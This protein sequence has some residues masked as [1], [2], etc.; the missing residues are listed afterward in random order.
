[1][2]STA[3]TNGQDQPFTIDNAANDL[4]PR[5]YQIDK[6]S[7]NLRR[8][9]WQQ[10][11]NDLDQVLDEERQAWSRRSQKDLRL[12]YNLPDA[13]QPRTAS[14]HGHD[15]VA[16]NTRH[17]AQ[18]ESA[19]NQ[20]KSNFREGSMNEGSRATAS[21]W[22]GSLS[23][24]TG[25][26][27]ASDRSECS[28]DDSGATPRPSIA[29]RASTS[30]SFD[31]EEFKPPPV[32]PSTLKSTIKRL[33][34]KLKPGESKENVPTQMVDIKTHRT[35]KRG[36][37]KS[38]STWRI[39]NSTNT[40]NEGTSDAD[41][42]RVKATKTSKAGRRVKS[43]AEAD[44]IDVQRSI[45]DDR[46]RKA[47]IAYSQQFGTARKRQKDSSGLPNTPVEHASPGPLTATKRMETPVD[48]TIARAMESM[49]HKINDN[50]KAGATS[51]PR[52][53]PAGSSP[54]PIGTPPASRHGRS[55][56]RESSLSFDSDT[57]RRKRQRVQYYNK[58]E[59]ENQ[60][61]RLKLKE[62]EGLLN[63]QTSQRAASQQH[64]DTD[65]TPLSGLRS[66][67]KNTSRS[68]LDPNWKPYEEQPQLQPQP[69]IPPRSA[70]RPTTNH[71]R[72]Y[73]HTS[74][75]ASPL[76][77][78]TP[79][80][81][82]QPTITIQPDDDDIPP[83]PPL[84]LN[85]SKRLILV[86]TTANKPPVTDTATIKRRPPISHHNNI[87]PGVLFELPR[88]LSMVLEGIEDDV[89]NSDDNDENSF[90]DKVVTTKSKTQSPN[91]TTAAARSHNTSSIQKENIGVK[92]KLAHLTDDKTDKNG[93]EWQWPEDAF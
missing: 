5:K 86:P 90:S 28:D 81:S 62:S 27:E 1:M 25:T 87:E 10:E 18:P 57:D 43:N 93:G 4:R 2:Q 20:R 44:P 15:A 40:D 8:R 88:P 19:R 75:S 39:F 42:E 82:S 22:Q 83:L 79:S 26:I 78:S 66:T 37:R 67:S 71:A 76:K 45:L 48:S 47:E 91:K 46:K 63:L 12:Q 41:D 9:A 84:P 61:L 21:T 74:Q 59:K 36:L 14:N 6:S 55:L 32:T 24:Q 34:Q 72:G 23:S 92:R 31:I 70:S 65:S 73:I 30:S 3:H 7:L 54:L 50:S 60:H 29:G 64:H 51:S 69:P 68:S 33:G 49:L 89:N 80:R 85:L 77:S 16:V 53:K 56:S 13:V 38:M 17:E 35:P 52:G 58:L 11:D